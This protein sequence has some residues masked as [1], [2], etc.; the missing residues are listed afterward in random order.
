MDIEKTLQNILEM[1]VQDYK[2]SPR[3]KAIEQ[4]LKKGIFRYSE[5]EMLAQESGEILNRAFAKYL[6]DVLTNG[7]LYRATAEV[8]LKNPL[9]QSS[10]DVRDAAIRIQRGMN[11]AAGIGINP[12]EPEIN[13]DQIDGIITG[14]CNAR[15]YE[16][17]KEVLFDRTQNFLEG[18]V[19]DF[20]RENAEFHYKAGLEPTI[21]RR[22]RGKCCKWCSELAG[23]YLYEDVRDKGHEVWR[24]HR[25]CHCEV[26]YN[27]GNGSKRRQNAH[28]RRWTDESNP[29]II[30]E[31]KGLL[32][33]DLQLFASKSGE[34]RAQE[35]RSNWEKASL[36]ETVKKLVPNATTS[37]NR[38][39]GKVFYDDPDS[40]Y[41]VV[42]DR[43]GNY[44]RVKDK[45][46]TARKKRYVG[47]DGESML[48]KTENGRTIGR[49]DEEYEKA[50]H[51]D[52]ID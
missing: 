44:F 41:Q 42:Y 33:L 22:A 39:K 9:L 13:M 17:G 48:N 37:E 27:P 7:S 38:K 1:Y 50:T 26:L 8:V 46:S 31:R 36:K 20:V 35:Y 19:D 25:N 52:N 23:N 29:A 24:R 45:E 15:S 30:E 49:S 32:K 21:E 5:A 18:Y 43:R 40:R 47:L 14:I 12:I 2:A 6:P 51:F 3:I 34:Y 11:E 16:A 28:T 4:K 10:R